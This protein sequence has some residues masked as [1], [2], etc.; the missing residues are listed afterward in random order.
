[1]RA[2]L[3][4]KTDREGCL[5]GG[6]SQRY[7]RVKLRLPAQPTTE[8]AP[9]CWGLALDRSGSMRGSKIGLARAALKEAI[10]RLDERDSFCVVAYETV[11]QMVVGMT[12]ATLAAKQAV[13]AQI[14]TIEPIGN[15]NL[16]AGFQLCSEQVLAGR[17]E[18]SVNR[19]ALISDGWATCG[20]RDPERV[21]ERVATRRQAGIVTCTLGVGSDFDQD[22]LHRVAEAGGGYF[23]YVQ[24]ESLL[25]DTLGAL[26]GD[27]QTVVASEARLVAECDPPLLLESMNDYPLRKLA[28]PAGLRVEVSLGDL[29]AQQE[30]S[31]VLRVTLPPMARGE[32]ARLRIRLGDAWGRIESD[33]AELTWQPLSA[34]ENLTQAKDQ[35]VLRAAAELF[36]AQ[37]RMRASLLNKAGR[38]AEAKQTLLDVA[39][40]NLRMADGDP[41]QFALARELEGEAGQMNSPLREEDSKALFTHEY[42]R[43][44]GLDEA[45]RPRRWTDDQTRPQALPPLPQ[46]SKGSGSV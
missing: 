34:D 8:R 3:T 25:S 24:H 44:R 20:L 11:A 22:M 12:R 27:S 42:T 5:D 41:E 46:T 23:H 16:H 40:S 4:A 38:F 10:S 18:R 13:A 28:Q 37:A 15:T 1:M 14:D 7:V 29:V 35:S 30:L 9:T 2:H 45:S 26:M 43:L 32:R 33:P 21:A 39:R 17:G 6:G 19:V 36:A 31:L